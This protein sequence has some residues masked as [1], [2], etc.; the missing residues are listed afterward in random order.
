MGSTS[1]QLPSPP[2]YYHFDLPLY[3]SDTPL[4]HLNHLQTDIMTYDA[5]T[6]TKIQSNQILYIATHYHNDKTFGWPILI[7]FVNEN[8]GN[9]SIIA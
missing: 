2:P 6:T 3:S 4:N 5:T 9:D 7:F 1:L 8:A